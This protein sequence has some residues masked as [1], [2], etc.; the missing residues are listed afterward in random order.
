[1]LG[2]REAANI[3]LTVTG[4]DHINMETLYQASTEPLGRVPGA[5]THVMWLSFGP[6]SHG[7]VWR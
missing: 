5:E 6:E 1:M 7:I 3:A 4:Q 2:R